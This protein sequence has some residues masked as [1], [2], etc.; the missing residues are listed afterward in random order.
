MP[1]SLLFFKKKK[2]K[3]VFEK[4]TFLKKRIKQKQYLMAPH[5]MSR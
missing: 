3:S 1:E 2:K 4:L 5:Q